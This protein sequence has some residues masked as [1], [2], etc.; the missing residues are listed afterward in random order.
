VKVFLCG[1][2]SDLVDERQGVLAKIRELRLQHESMEF[3][4]AR[5]DRPIDVC[6]AE[7]A[8]SSVLIVIVGHKY[9]SLVPGESISFSEAEYQRGNA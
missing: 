5:P 7:V 1:T 2:Y 9:G 4:G 3:F 6:L 8:R